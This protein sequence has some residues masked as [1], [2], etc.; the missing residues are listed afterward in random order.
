M[1][2][3]GGACER[4]TWGQSESEVCVL[5]PVAAHTH[6]RQVSFELTTTM[7]RVHVAAAAGSG[8]GVGGGGTSGAPALVIEGELHAPVLADEA[9]YEIE[10]D[11]TAGESAEGWRLVVRLV[12]FRKTRAN[13]HWPSVVRGEAVIDVARFGEPV[14]AIDEGSKGDVSRYMR[15]I[16]NMAEGKLPG[17]YECEFDGD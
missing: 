14:I 5:A 15:L 16:E 17:G 13:Q 3:M 11:E 12:K 8:D 6:P 1:M 9:T 2:E 4:Y 10:R 7:I